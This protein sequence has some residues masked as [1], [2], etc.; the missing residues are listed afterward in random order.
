[1]SQPGPPTDALHQALTTVA[2]GTPLRD[3]IERIVRAKMGALLVLGDGPDVLD[4]CSGGFLLDAPFSP[5]RLS[6]L[7]KMDGAIILGSHG[8]RLAWANVHLVPDPTVPTSETGTRHRTAERVARSIPVPVVSVSEEMGVINVYAG[9]MR[10]QL[11]DISRLLDRANQALQT[12]E[13]Y[14]VRLDDA[15]SSL[16]ALEVGEAATIRD[17]AAVVQRGEMVRRISAEIETMIIELGVDARLLRLQV[18]EIYG[19]IDRELE[20]VL[21][22]YPRIANNWAGHGL[23]GEAPTTPRGLRMLDRVPRITPQQATAIVDHFGDLSRLL[24][25][26]P[27]EIASVVGVDASL[28]IVVRDTLDR[29]TEASILDQFA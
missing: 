4:I 20:L 9:G 16:T 19:E 8:Q 21:A 7:A 27:T 1:M 3:G 11:Q 5:Q 23:D 26:T 18:D 29:V 15:L 25:A 14:K 22:D 10:H 2:P 12:L 13:R 28:G 17:V 24:R 6:E